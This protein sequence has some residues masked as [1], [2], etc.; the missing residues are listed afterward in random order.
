MSQFL[1]HWE[2]LLLSGQILAKMALPE[3]GRQRM[4]SGKWGVKNGCDF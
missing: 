2:Y 4:Y 1:F 3:C